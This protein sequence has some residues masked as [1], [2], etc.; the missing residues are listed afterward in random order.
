MYADNEVG[1]QQYHQETLCLLV[2]EWVGEGQRVLV[3]NH[4]LL[5]HSCK[6]FVFILFFI[7]LLI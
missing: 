5:L 2:R 7:F 6:W 4:V 3:I 1:W